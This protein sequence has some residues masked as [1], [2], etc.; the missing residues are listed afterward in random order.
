MSG[1]VRGER[2]LPR[3]LL[4]PQNYS[5]KFEDLVDDPTGKRTEAATHDSIFQIHLE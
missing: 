5:S 2:L 4:V 1:T 3:M